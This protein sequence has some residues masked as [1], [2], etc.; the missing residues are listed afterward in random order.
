MCSS[1]L[2]M[3][4]SAVR[5]RSSALFFLTIC[6]QSVEAPCCARMPVWSDLP[7]PYRNLVTVSRNLGASPRWLSPGLHP[8]PRPDSAIPPLP[9]LLVQVRLDLRGERP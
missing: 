6:R 1:K 7:Q 5:V 4:R 8:A 3:S 2:V 9:D